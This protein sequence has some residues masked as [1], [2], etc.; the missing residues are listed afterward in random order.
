M[1]EHSGQGLC[2]AFGRFN[3]RPRMKVRLWL[4]YAVRRYTRTYHTMRRK[5]F[6]S[7]LIVS[8]IFGELVCAVVLLGQAESRRFLRN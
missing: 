4:G 6:E 8:A 7:R 3:Q 2:Q 1:H 5:L